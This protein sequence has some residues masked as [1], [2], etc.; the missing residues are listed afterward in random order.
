MWHGV[1]RVR[2][3]KHLVVGV[4]CVD[5]NNHLLLIA[6][7][8]FNSSTL[9]TSLV[10][11]CIKIISIIVD[12]ISILFELEMRSIHH[13]RQSVSFDWSKRT[14]PSRQEKKNPIERDLD[15]FNN[16]TIDTVYTYYIITLGWIER[17]IG[18][19]KNQK[20]ESAPAC[21]AVYTLFWECGTGGS[22]SHWHGFQNSRR[23]R[24]RDALHHL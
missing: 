13:H 11:K 6:H 24:Q 1:E 5:Q 14:H 10:N 15:G 17:P 7:C 21:V 12:I 23:N 9:S 19:T 3:P 22:N 4:V 16:Y 2:Y 18:I 8:L 20:I